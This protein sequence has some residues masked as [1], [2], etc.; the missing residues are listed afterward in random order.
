MEDLHVTGCPL[1]KFTENPNVPAPPGLNARDEVQAEAVKLDG[2]GKPEHQ[3]Y[4]TR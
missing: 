2:E 4:G 1:L 3:K